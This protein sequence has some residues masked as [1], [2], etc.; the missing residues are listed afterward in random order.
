MLKNYME[1]VV[2]QMLPDILNERELT[3]NCEFCIEDIKAI[4]LNNL[5][6]KYVV[7]KKGILYTKLNEFSV[8]FRA[9]VTREIVSAIKIVKDM[10]RH[11][12]E[13]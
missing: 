7:T 10:P 6:P 5:K 4:A 12:D 3:C 8:Q 2:D 9:D 1:I 13:R 11:D